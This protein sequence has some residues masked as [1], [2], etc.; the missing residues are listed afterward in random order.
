M[1]SWPTLSAVLPQHSPG[2]TMENHDQ[3]SRLDTTAA[4]KSLIMSKVCV[5]GHTH[6]ARHQRPLYS[7]V[8][9]S[10]SRPWEENPGLQS[11][12]REC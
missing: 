6:V 7:R 10:S 1:Q 8:Y 4:L 9:M 5:L 2:G 12:R 11:A 3:G